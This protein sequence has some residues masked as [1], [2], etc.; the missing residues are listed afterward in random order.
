PTHS[1]PTTYTHLTVIP[2]TPNGKTDT[3]ALPTPGAAITDHGPSG[4]PEGVYD[5]VRRIWEEV[6]LA[7]AIGPDDRLFDIGGA[8][9]HIARIHSA[10]TATYH[11]DNL[12]MTDLFAR[13]TLRT[14]TERVLAL[15]A[16]TERTPMGQTAR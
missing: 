1:T 12:R 9:L 7:S 2:L 10:V 8:S 16:A 15:M 11:L 4:E 6:T 3:T 14:Y 5:T 13:P